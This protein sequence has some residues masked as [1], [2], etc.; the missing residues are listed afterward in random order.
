[1]T[2]TQVQIARKLNL[3]PQQYAKQVAIDMRKANG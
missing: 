3:T 1:L 2:R